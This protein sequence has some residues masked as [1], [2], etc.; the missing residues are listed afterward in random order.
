MKKIAGIVFDVLLWILMLAL[1][2]L[3]LSGIYQRVLQKNGYT[4]FLGI[5]Y[6]VV[7]SGSMEP[8]IHINDMIVYQEKDPGKLNLHDVI[9]YKRAEPDGSTVLITHRIV[10]MD[11]ST[12]TTKGDA[13]RREDTPVPYERI[14]GKVLFKIPYMGYAVSFMKSPAGALSAAAVCA[15]VLFLEIAPYRKKHRK[16]S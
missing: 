4:G 16:Q 5:G 11:D 10:S 12:V 2:F 8:Q 9:V 6:A 14:V 1:L 13:N 15:L 7:V 3:V